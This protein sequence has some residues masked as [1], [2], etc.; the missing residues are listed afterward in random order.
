MVIQQSASQSAGSGGGSG[1][2]LGSLRL[3]SVSINGSTGT[4]LATP[5]GTVLS[6]TRGGVAYTV[7]GSVTPY[8][9]ETASRALTQHAP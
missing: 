2:G 7:L 5:L 4:E 9:A 6:F 1:P 3:P 8:A